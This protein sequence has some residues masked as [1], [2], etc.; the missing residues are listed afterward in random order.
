MK[1]KQP[2]DAWDYKVLQHEGGMINLGDPAELSSLKGR[3]GKW[4]GRAGEQR[5][6]YSLDD[7]GFVIEPE[8]R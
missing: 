7:C 5:W 4:R 8:V 6:T 1:G 2:A 3:T